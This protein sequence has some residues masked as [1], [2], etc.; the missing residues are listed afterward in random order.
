MQVQRP[1]ILKVSQ[2]AQMESREETETEKLELQ[3]FVF[4]M[5]NSN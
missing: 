1:E 3:L 5:W 2:Q 4:E